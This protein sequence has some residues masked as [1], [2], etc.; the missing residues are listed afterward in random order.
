MVFETILKTF[1]SSNFS[2][3][4]FLRKIPKNKSSHLDEAYFTTD[5]LRDALLAREVEGIL[6]D[7]YTAGSR[8][9]LFERP[10]LRAVN[11][12]KYLRSYGFV[13]SGNL[14]NLAVESRDWVSANQQEI[15]RLVQES[16]VRMEVSSNCA[17]DC[18]SFNVASFLHENHLLHSFF[19]PILILRILFGLLIN[20]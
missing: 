5:Q 19:Q 2:L 6:V 8:S 11:V 18:P 1:S 15:L 7:A 13:M 4:H 16:T 3:P 12:Y 10:E 20:H 9:Q 14:V 17:F